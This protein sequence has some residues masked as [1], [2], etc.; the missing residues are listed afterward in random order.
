MSFKPSAAITDASDKPEDR[1]L[2]IL[3]G[4]IH[5]SLA[6]FLISALFSISITQG[7]LFVGTMAWLIKVLLTR[8]WG[9]LRFPLW[10]PILIFC[11]AS[12]IAVAA[13]VDPVYSL[14]SLKKLLQFVIIFWV[15]NAVESGR[16]RDR[17]V[18]ILISAASLAA[19]YGFYQVAVSGKMAGS[20][21]AVD[22]FLPV[23]DINA[24]GLVGISGGD[25]FPGRGLEAKTALGDSRFFCGSGVVFSLTGPR[26]GSIHDEH[27]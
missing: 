8:S 23:V 20:A 18:L 26:E 7:I 1:S 24:P 3:D 27:C 25:G 15:V 22:R 13:A 12:L 9:Q 5:A 14:P 10:L 6:G 4:V 21:C 11:S 16:H 2:K 17:L 19:I